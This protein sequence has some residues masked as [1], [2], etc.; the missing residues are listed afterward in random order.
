MARSRPN[1][2]RATPTRCG[3]SSGPAGRR[4]SKTRPAASA[5]Y[6]YD[7]KTRLTGEEDQLGNLSQNVYD[8]QDH[9]VMTLSPLGETNQT[10]FDG[11]HNPVLTIDAVGFTNQY[12]YDAAFNLIRAV[13]A[14]GH[15]STF[16]YNAQFSLTGATNG[17]GDWVAFDYNADGTPKTRTDSAAWAFSAPTNGAVKSHHLSEQPGSEGFFNNAL[18]EC[19]PTP[20][21]AALPPASNTTAAA[22]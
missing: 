9:V 5:G 18:G 17:A 22:N 1:T 7:D 6:F 3:K 4:W 13:D 19:S 21:P 16:G 8:G 10:V 12:F 20:T 2:P 15:P 11:Y 14:D